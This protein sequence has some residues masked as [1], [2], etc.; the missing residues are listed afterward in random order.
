MTSP[1]SALFEPFQLGPLQLANRIAMAPMTRSFSPGGIPGEN[2]AAYYRRR[3]EGGTGLLITEGTYVG[4]GPTHTD[5]AVPDFHGE[6]ALAGWRNVV[7]QVHA[8]GAKI[9]PQLWHVGLIEV[10]LSSLS[11]ESAYRPELGLIG[12]SGVL[13]PDREV[14]TPMTLADIDAVIDAFTTAAVDAQRL[15]FDGVELHGAHGYLID[16]FFWGHTN[17]RTDRYGATNKDRGRFAGEIVAEIRRRTGPDY[18]ILLRISQWKQQ[19]YAARMA[20]TPEALAELLEPSVS[21]GVSMLHCSQRRFWEPAFDGSEDNLA[22]AVKKLTGLPTMTVGSVGLDIEFLESLVER[23]IA[24]PV[25]VDRLAEMIAR[26]DFDM[27]AIGRA[28]IGDPHW[29]NK[30]RDGDVA[31]LQDFDAAALQAL[32]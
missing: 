4:H 15:G 24:A 16:Q 5:A 14:T 19:N 27:V 8:A 10:R 9:M 32:I 23:K 7:E 18:P 26:G 31:G 2:V 25:S 29:P 28:L 30:I 12:P 22:A 1:L 6:Q 21:A 17:R 11:R 13:W 3:A 20:E